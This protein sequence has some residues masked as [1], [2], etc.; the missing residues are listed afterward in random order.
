MELLVVNMH[1]LRNKVTVDR[2][3]MTSLNTVIRGDWFIR[4]TTNIKYKNNCA[5]VYVGSSLTVHNPLFSVGKL[6][7]MEEI[8]GTC[9]LVNKIKMLR[10]LLNIDTVRTKTYNKGI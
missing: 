1:I 2:I 10:M 5:A 6:I 4:K 7:V 8:N 3:D 9:L